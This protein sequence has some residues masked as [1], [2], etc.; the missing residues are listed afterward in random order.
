MEASIRGTSLQN[1]KNIN[2]ENQMRL[3]DHT[4]ELFFLLAQVGK[5]SFFTQASPECD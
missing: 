3:R 5:L 1:K 4:A 2:N